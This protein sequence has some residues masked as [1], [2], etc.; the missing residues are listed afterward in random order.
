MTEYIQYVCVFYQSIYSVKQ[1]GE[2][3]FKNY[4]TAYVSIRVK[5][6]AAPENGAEAG[7]HK[8]DLFSSTDFL[9]AMSNMTVIII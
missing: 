2:I 5:F 9:I 4:Y 6:K 8:Q 3:C 7:I 1:V